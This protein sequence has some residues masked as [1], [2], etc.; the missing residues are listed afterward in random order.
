MDVV[1]GVHAERHT[2]SVQNCAVVTVRSNTG[3][4]Y[5]YVLTIYHHISKLIQ[6]FE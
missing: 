6:Y 3:M 4:N 1:I 5:M 2:G